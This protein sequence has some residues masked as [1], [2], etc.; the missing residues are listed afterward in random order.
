MSETIDMDMS[1]RKPN[2]LIGVDDV[3]V[4]MRRISDGCLVTVWRLSK[5]GT[6]R[7]FESEHG[8]PVPY[9]I[10]LTT[11]TVVIEYPSGWMGQRSDGNTDGFGVCDD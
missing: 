3:P 8:D 4:Q 1:K 10:E 11:G 6:L 2:A 7:F 5:P 9:D